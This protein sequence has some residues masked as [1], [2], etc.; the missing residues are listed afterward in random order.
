MNLYKMLLYVIGLIC[1][2][3]DFCMFHFAIHIHVMEAQNLFAP[4]SQLPLF[5]I[6]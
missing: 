4:I 3:T 5:E 6:Q 1:I 2:C